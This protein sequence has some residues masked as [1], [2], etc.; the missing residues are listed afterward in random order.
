M[1]WRKLHTDCSWKHPLS[2]LIRAVPNS[3]QSLSLHLTSTTNHSLCVYT[4]EFTCNPSF[5]LPSL[6]RTV[7]PLHIQLSTESGEVLWTGVIDLKK[8]YFV[9][10]DLQDLE[11][12][13]SFVVL[14][15][16]S[17]QG[18]YTTEEFAEVACGSA[19]TNSDQQK[20]LA[21]F[22]A[23]EQQINFHRLQEKYAQ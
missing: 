22:C 8:L 2:V 7:Y 17:D 9:T 19:Q 12:P 3:P 10:S 4:E 6:P 20:I 21:T 5:T 18:Y 11:R 23:Q 14:F 15:L 13:A 1:E 16:F